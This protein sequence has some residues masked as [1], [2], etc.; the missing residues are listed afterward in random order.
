M[1][2]QRNNSDKKETRGKAMQTTYSK[3]DIEPNDLT[4]LERQKS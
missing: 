1:R 3:G 4:Y 2:S